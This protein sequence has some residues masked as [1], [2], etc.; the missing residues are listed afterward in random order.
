MKLPA[1][2]DLDSGQKDVLETP[3][4]QNL[5]VVGPPGSGKTILIVK[6]ASQLQSARISVNAI[7]YNRMLRRR[8]ALWG[9]EAS[10]M[11]SFMWN[12]F[13]SRSG[14]PCPFIN[15]W[16][17]DWKKI[18]ACLNHKSATP[19]SRHLLVD[20]GQDLPSPFF[21]Y[22]SRHAADC[23]TVAADEEQALGS[24][25][26]TLEEIKKSSGLDNP[27]MLRYNYRNVPEVVAVAKHF[28]Q[29]RLP[30]AQVR[31][32]KTGERPRLRQ[33]RDSDEVAGWISRWLSNR[34]GTI[35]VIVRRKEYGKDICKR[36]RR[37]LRGKRVDYYDSDL[38]NDGAIDL[39]ASGVTVL[40]KESVKGQEFDMVAITQLDRFLPC[41]SPEDFR[42]MYMMC[43]RARTHLFLLHEGNLDKAVRDAL[44]GARVLER[45]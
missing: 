41:Q 36:T 2:E 15:K 6:R 1:W 8:L 9:C 3:L 11:H 20:E 45:E 33:V 30:V 21:R 23:L 32:K 27:V 40:T 14:K 44:P 7:T 35:G 39:D 38:Q 17:L 13:A 12:D 25:H 4:D 34:G 37:R 10:T 42:A 19:D 18:E 26:T 24:R 16:D 31:R 29:G 43:T 5:F 22:A 28:H